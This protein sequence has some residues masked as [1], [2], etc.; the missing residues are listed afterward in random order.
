MDSTYAALLEK[1]RLPQPSFQ[2]FAVVSLFRHLESSLG[3]LGPNSGVCHDAI[4][5]CL[6]SPF[7]AVVDQAVHELCRL[8]AVGDRLSISVALIELQS[9]LEGC[10]KRFVPVFV[11]GIGFLCR[12][13]FC[14][15]SSW[16]R[17]FER[18]DLHPFVKVLSCCK[19]SHE[20]LIEQV[21]LFIVRNKYLGINE[22]VRFLRPFIVFSMIWKSSSACVYFF[23]R[24]LI[25]AIAS[26]S[27][28]FPLEAISILKLLTDCLKYLPLTNQEEFLYIVTSAEHIVDAFVVV[29]QQTVD[30][31]KD[32]ATDAQRCSVEVLCMLLSI[33]ASFH[34]KP[35]VQ[36][37]PVIEI[38]RHLLVAQKELGLCYAFEFVNIV[39]S[40][41]V[42]LAQVEFE[43]DQLSVL[44]LLI[45][46][47][48]WKTEDLSTKRASCS[49]G[50]EL[51]TVFPVINLL[52]SPSKP[53][54]AA[55]TH[56]LSLAE[57]FVLNFMS[58]LKK[59]EVSF[60]D[61]PILTEAETI[62]LRLLHHL[63]T[64]GQE[65]PYSSYFFLFTSD[66]ITCDNE[67]YCGPLYWT[68]WLREHLLTIE[69]EKVTFPP[70][71]SDS[72]Y[73]GVNI[74]LGSIAYSLVISPAFDT[75]AVDLLVA[76]GVQNPKLGMTIFQ[77]ALF[78]INILLKF[79][80]NSSKILLNLL[81]MLPSLA[82]NSAMV[83]II[84]QT[85]LP[86]L[87]KDAKLSLHAVAIRL[88]CKT[89]VVSD[90]GVLSPKTLSNF[91]PVREICVSV[92][93]SVRD[94]CKENPDR[95]VDLILSLS[96]CIESEDSTVKAL[97]LRSLS[98]LCEADVVDF[99][100]AW[101][102]VAKHVNT[103][104]EEPVVAAGLVTLLR[105][106]ALDVETYPDI[107]KIIMLV[108]WEVG[109]LRSYSSEYLWVKART[110]A[111][112]SMMH[113]EIV[114]FQEIIPEF[115]ETMLQCFLNECNA[116][117]LEAMEEFEIKIINFEHI[118]RRRALKE[119]R[120]LGYKVAK[121][122][123]VFPQ[124]LFSPGNL[125]VNAR[126]FPGAALLSYVFTP[127]ELQGLSNDIPRIHASFEKALME[128]AESLPLSRNILIALLTLESWKAFIQQWIKA[129]V[130][131]SDAKS[132]S[133]E[134]DNELKSAA[135]ILKICRKVAEETVPQV[136]I[137]AALAIGALC[138]VVPSSSYAVICSATDF[139]LKWLVD[140]EHEHHQWSSAISLGLISNCFHATDRMLKMNVIT[141]LIQE[142]CNSKSHLVIGA[143]GLGLGFACQGLL[144]SAEVDSN[145]FA[146]GNLLC[147]VIKTLSMI[148]SKL[149]PLASDS[150]EN[151]FE[152][153]L[154]NGYDSAEASSVLP[155][156]KLDSLE[157]EEPWGVAGLVLGLGNCVF[158]MYRL[159]LNDAVLI[160]KD[161]LI[162]WVPSLEPSNKSSLF[163]NE[164]TEVSLAV[165]ACLAIPMVV[166]FCQNVELMIGD[167]DAILIRY[168]SLVSDLLNSSVSGIHYQNLVMASC[169]GAGSFI[170]CILNDGVNSIRYDDIKHLLELL[171][172]GYSKSHP[173]LVHLGA[174]IGVV[175]AFGAAAGDLTY[176]HIQA[177]FLPISLD[178][179]VSDY[180]RGPI[181]LSPI[182]ENLSTSFV[183]E[184]FL[185]AKDSKDQQTRK[186]AA[187]AVS[188]LRYKWCSEMIQ[189]IDCSKSIS[190]IPALQSQPLADD[191][192][193]WKMCSWLSNINYHQL[194]ND[195]RHPMIMVHS[196]TVVA[197]LRC[198]SKAPKLP[199]LDWASII[200]GFMKNV[201][202]FPNKSE[203]L[204]DAT[205]FREECI[206]FSLAHA[207]DVKSLLLF[208]DD[209]VDLSRFRTLELNL[210]CLLLRQVS[211]LTNIF[212]TLRIERLFQDFAQFFSS[213][214]SPYL[215]YG[216]KQK[217]LLRI[218]FWKG[219][220]Q[221]LNG[222][223]LESSCVS[224]I[225][226]CMECLFRF[227][228]TF[229]YNVKTE[230]F[231][232]TCS[233]WCE[234]IRCLT[235]ARHGWLIVVLQF[236]DRSTL[237]EIAVRILAK[238]RLVKNGSFSFSELEKLKSFILNFR[239]EGVWWSVSIKRQW[240]LD[241]LDV[242]CVTENPSTAISFVGLLSGS[243]SKYM[244]LLIV[245]PEIVLSDLPITLPSLLSS[246][247]WSAI[248]ESCVDKLWQSTE[249]ICTW[250][251]MLS[252][253][254]IDDLPNSNRINESNVDAS[255]DVPDLPLFE[256][257][258]ATRPAVEV[259]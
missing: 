256:R 238:V 60:T 113:Y 36:V 116:E 159:G 83:K 189:E 229:A 222:A 59:T 95:G 216:L 56:L 198:I 119:R 89:W 259:G 84:V 62:P 110:I 87:H 98:L 230:E 53:I 26:L 130:T 24:N 165:G 152:S 253:G 223:Y 9:A 142:A 245:K 48:E 23:S 193:V 29:L 161:I 18:V 181:I 217:V 139:L 3:A 21:M 12:F 93:A 213:S 86:M 204:Q 2:R 186:Y 14:I 55:V 145:R 232:W 237:N 250:A 127:K 151:L 252:G 104:T 241:A 211:D 203:I 38:S 246:S 88:L 74:L 128:I 201:V 72:H 65:L 107:A 176:K 33:C 22:V 41:S 218:S 167:I 136:S 244:P 170:S 207:K 133:S 257:L 13:A 179:M 19:E 7:A 44:K 154:L 132:S 79:E 80:S 100:T 221:C 180:V 112:Q 147:D 92:A 73:E 52:S 148:L 233:E 175:N 27:C 70:Q 16:G 141:V 162:S 69:R 169:I 46:L 174:M 206:D 108:L 251:V 212:S 196:N 30:I 109:T 172:N 138:L 158:A 124:A 64:Q 54:R 97:G 121:L 248:A 202:N 103:Y 134:L 67:K 105:W 10:E 234:A 190:M 195:G 153:F 77:A 199:V 39:V 15:D 51:L 254:A 114:K 99:Y 157:D 31:E 37:E 187:W 90:R 140:S 177:S 226:K 43:H 191:S 94:V 220:Y 168:V 111:F 61:C 225:E 42:I 68:S 1:T 32:V 131:S 137:N 243:C 35:L 208:L 118:N 6:R 47:M 255:I 228:P 215:V 239:L 242:S 102:V 82:S 117:V 155:Q 173:P 8:V 75:S 166:E 146:E 144:S 183:Q 149:C 126:E 210:Q 156:C 115:K 71:S 214:A 135:D 76:F 11:K 219:L 247:S 192:L 25:S 240:L 249:R 235:K 125:N 231:L 45:L 28:S 96:S 197:V 227:M 163:C 205:S 101:E 78:Y 160:L 258:L 209:L 123:D 49:L 188:F 164:M 81:E 236:S 129:L 5:Q 122:L 20:E 91:E 178:L 17:R 85:V 63:F 106:G 150:L 171:R 224:E 120:P 182:C 50:E 34:R 66:K 58:V 4:S 143:C 184:L 40:A 185:V 200:R 194:S 57:S